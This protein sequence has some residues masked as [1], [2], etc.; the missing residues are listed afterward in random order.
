MWELDHKKGWAPKNW[1]FWTVVLERTLESLLDCKEIK[2]V[3]S[4][5]NQPWIFIRRIDAEAEAPILWPPHGKSLLFGKDP[6]AGKDW[7]QE[8]QGWQR[9]RWL[10][11]ITDSVN[12]LLLFTQLS[13]SLCDPMDCSMPG[14]PVL[15][16]LP[17]FA[18]TRVH[19]VSDAIQPSHPVI[20]FSSH[21]QSFPASRSFPVCQSFTSGGQSIGA[22][23]SASILPMKIQGWFILG[24]SGLISLQPRGLSRVFSSTTI[25]KHPFFRAQA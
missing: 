6:D 11:G 17:K 7:R 16:H 4:K 21:L 12:M 10:N 13:L 20:P 1:C 9:T 5:G 3:N 8:E 2:P 19:W 18:Q 23:A 14:F 24:L 15:H 25:W 22:S